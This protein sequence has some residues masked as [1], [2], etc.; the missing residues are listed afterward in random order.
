MGFFNFGK[1]KDTKETNHTSWESC[2]K[3]QPNMYEKDGKRY[4][5]FTLKEGVDTV[6]CLQPAEVYSVDKPEEVE[7]RLLLLSTTEDTLI[8]N[9]PFYKSVRF[10]KDYVVEDK[11]PLVLLRGL[12]LEDMKIFVQNMEVA[13]Q[14]EQ[15]IREIC[16][17]TDE[18]LQAE[19]IAP[20]TVEAV[21]HS[22]H[23]KTYTFEQVY[24]PSG[25]LIAADPICELQSMYVP[26]IKETIPSGY[27]PITIGILD[28]ELVGIRMTGMC[29]K[30]T[31]EE[32]LSYQ[33]ATMYKAK[34]KK[35]FRAAF[36]VDAGMSTFC[37]KEAAESYWK[38][39]YAW[40]KEHPNGNWYND[41]L[42]DLFKESAEAYPDLQREGGDFIR[43]KIPESNNEIVMVA[44]GFG[45]G[46]YQV[47]WG[48]DKNG[49]RC[50]LVTLF[51]DPRKA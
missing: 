14:E 27:Y 7:Y 12:T 37:D 51:V 17:Q 33:A 16:E 18:L 15:T 25:T 44:T 3:A 23:V 24:F 2:H 42:A 40:Y 46:I 38:V 5:F 39:L 45:D 30:V 10:L 4:M 32:A 35:E 28:S 8:G 21:F 29:L 34:D 50:E 41:Y 13:L 36:P 19:T 6:L 49:K 31:E 20:E 11:F 9:L 26:V 43:F 22:R 48:V 1:N 47:F